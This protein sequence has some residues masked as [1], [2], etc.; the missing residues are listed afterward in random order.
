MHGPFHFDAWLIFMVLS[1]VIMAVIRVMVNKVIKFLHH[2]IWMRRRAKGTLV[3]DMEADYWLKLLNRPDWRPIWRWFY[4]E[5]YKKTALFT[6]DP[7]AKRHA[8]R[9]RRMMLVSG[10]LVILIV[11]AGIGT[12]MKSNGGTLTPDII[13]PLKTTLEPFSPT[14]LTAVS[15]N[16]YEVDRYSS[17]YVSLSFFIQREDL[18]FNRQLVSFGL[19]SGN[20][21]RLID[22]EIEI[23]GNFVL[24]V[25]YWTYTNRIDV[26]FGMGPDRNEFGLTWDVP[27]KGSILFTVVLHIRTNLHWVPRG[28][29]VAEFTV[30]GNSQVV[31]VLSPVP[32]PVP[33]LP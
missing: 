23:R 2:V 31:F 32:P 26:P 10:I 14:N 8:R 6:E 4:S 27:H 22:P 1:F 9:I 3:R 16:A 29:V 21:S 12:V 28:T 7:R 19:K 5:E 20:Y 25:T 11:I 33:E 24:N 17:S 13:I 30:A 15:S 18:D